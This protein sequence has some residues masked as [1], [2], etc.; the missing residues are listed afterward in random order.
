MIVFIG[1]EKSGGNISDAPIQSHAEVRNQARVFVASTQAPMVTRLARSMPPTSDH[2]SPQARHSMSSL[3]SPRNT[4]ASDSSVTR[5]STIRPWGK[6]TARIRE[7]L[8]R[9]NYFVASAAE[10]GVL[11]LGENVDSSERRRRIMV[12]AAQYHWKVETR[13]DGNSARFLVSPPS[14]LFPCESLSRNHE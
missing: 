2:S 13:A 9:Q 1:E 12:Y 6:L 14:G 3:V 11:W 4:S 7:A 5:E 10:L 8:A